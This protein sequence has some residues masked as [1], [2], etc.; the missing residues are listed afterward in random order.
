[1]NSP[2]GFSPKSQ[3][4]GQALPKGVTHFLLITTCAIG[5]T[6]LHGSMDL[7][8]TWSWVAFAATSIAS[9]AGL[10]RGYHLLD[11]HLANNAQPPQKPKPLTSLFLLFAAA[12]MSAIIV[13]AYLGFLRGLCRIFE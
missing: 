7:D 3:I 1:M 8:V 2:K 9:L 5:A 11:K 10:T 6:A 13:A 4:L 12:A